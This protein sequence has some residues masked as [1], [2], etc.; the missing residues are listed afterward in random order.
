MARGSA[1]WSEFG[2]DA[3]GQ[4]ASIHTEIGGFLG[5]GATPVQ[6]PIA[7]TTVTEQNVQL[8]ATQ[9]QL[10]AFI[11]AQKNA[12][13]NAGNG[14]ASAELASNAAAGVVATAAQ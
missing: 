2:I 8:M 13:V 12:S 3:A 4:P 9:A 7:I 6:F 10:S 14:A 1:R 5:V 11:E